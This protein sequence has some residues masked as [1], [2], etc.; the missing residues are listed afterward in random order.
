[1]LRSLLVLTSAIALLF[2]T[3]PTA[4]AAQPPSGYPTDQ[5]KQL[6][7]HNNRGEIPLRRGFWDPEIDNRYSTT[8]PPEKG[9]GFGT[10]KAEHKHNFVNLNLMQFVINNT[11]GNSQM[12][13]DRVN[14]SSVLFKS[15][16]STMNCVP[17]PYGDL[18]ICEYAGDGGGWQG[19]YE[20]HVVVETDY[21]DYY[22]SWPASLNDDKP[23]GLLTA[24]CN[25]YPGKCPDEVN[26]WTFMEGGPGTGQ[27]FA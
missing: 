13:E 10:D 3:P 9:E 7:V 4:L 12:S 22:Y 18:P 20:I 21:S 8:T 1:M 24:F 15:F 23:V 11:N 14:Y 27:A 2:V 16:V 6:I 19:P 26:Y 25:G 5:I 17:N